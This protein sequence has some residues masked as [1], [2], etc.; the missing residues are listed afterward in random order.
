MLHLI[1]L[2]YMSIHQQAL[3]PTSLQNIHYFLIMFHLTK[4]EVIT[5][6]M[7][8]LLTH[9]G[10]FICLQ[11]LWLCIDEQLQRKWS[12]ELFLDPSLQTVVLMIRTKAL[13]SRVGSQQPGRK[14]V[15]LGMKTALVINS[16]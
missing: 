1:K 7:A 12:T 4:V 14:N 3:Q 11:G 15:F 8:S 16:D 13:G 5:R 10:V 2:H 9:L 6:K